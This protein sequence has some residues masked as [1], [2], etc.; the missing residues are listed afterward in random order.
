ML[1]KLL[2]VQK[3]DTLKNTITYKKFKEFNNDIASFQAMIGNVFSLNN[4]DILPNDKYSLGGRW[5][6]GFDNYGA[7]P[8]DSRTSYIGGN[9][10][11]A[12]KID[13]SK[14]LFKNDE[15][16]LYFNLFNDI[17][18]VWDNKTTPFHSDEKLRSSAGFGIKVLFIHWSNS[19]Y[20]G[21][22]NSRRKL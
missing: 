12:T 5:L 13:Y 10:I 22:P 20:L 15:N 8:R 16:P 14:L 4:S 7:G 21:F 19:F 3:M 17:G 9:N 18:L 2:Q 1:L 6:R 11:L